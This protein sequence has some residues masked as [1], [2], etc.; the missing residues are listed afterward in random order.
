MN[1][2]VLFVA[3]AGWL[4]ACDLGDMPPPLPPPAHALGQVCGSPGDCPD[5]PAHA[6]VTLSIGSQTQGYCS[7]ACASDADCRNGYTGPASGTPYCVN[8]DEPNTCTIECT[9]PTD[10]PDALDCVS[11]GGPSSL[12]VVPAQSLRP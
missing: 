3:C 11:A 1:R 10:C 7:P 12:C 2:L 5:W 9:S 6:C 8:P 4:A